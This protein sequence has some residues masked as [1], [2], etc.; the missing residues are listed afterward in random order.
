MGITYNP[1]EGIF[2]FKGNSSVS[3]NIKTDNIQLNAAQ[4]A[5][6]QVTLSQT[7][8]EATQVLLDIP[9]GVTQVYGP[10]FSVSGNIL[11]WNGLGLETILE[12]NDRLRIVY[13]Y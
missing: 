8:I 10:D 1:I 3:G 9:S 7:P 11:T 6:K 4:V 12:I 5:N 13:Q 2:D